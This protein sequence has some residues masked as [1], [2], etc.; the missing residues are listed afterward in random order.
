MRYTSSNCIHTNFIKDE[1]LKKALTLAEMNARIGA[2]QV[3]QLKGGYR[4]GILYCSAPQTISQMVAERWPDAE[5]N[6][7]ERLD[8]K[9]NHSGN[10]H[11]QG[12]S[13]GEKTESGTLPLPGGFSYANGPQKRKGGRPR[14]HTTDAT[15]QR[16]NAAYQRAYRAKSKVTAVSVE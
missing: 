16:A 10:P 3:G 6:T 12:T 9:K 7:Q 4:P 15:K 8:R 13:E 5:N 14:K 1:T 2:V 11:K